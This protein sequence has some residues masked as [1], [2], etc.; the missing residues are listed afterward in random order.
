MRVEFYNNRHKIKLIQ[1]TEEPYTATEIYLRYFEGIVLL[2]TY[3][4]T[5]LVSS[6]VIADVS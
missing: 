6:E 1:K 3:V 4:N 5:E 2:E